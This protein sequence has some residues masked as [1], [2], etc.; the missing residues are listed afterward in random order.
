MYSEAA[1]S[2]MFLQVLQNETLAQSKRNAHHQKL[3]FPYIH[4]QGLSKPEGEKAEEQG[5]SATRKGMTHINV[6]ITKKK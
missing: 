6:T 2:I 4:S 3:T 1:M 5:M